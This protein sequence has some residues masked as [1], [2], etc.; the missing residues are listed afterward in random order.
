MILFAGAH[1]TNPLESL[2]TRLSL[3]SRTSDFAMNQPARANHP[4]SQSFNVMGPNPLSYP[5]DHNPDANS[6][7][8]QRE[9]QVQTD[10]GAAHSS[11]IAYEAQPSTSS[12]A[13][14][15]RVT[16]TYQPFETLLAA[17]RNETG[18]NMFY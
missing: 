18:K 13:S 17:V 7:N 8:S 15:S 11:S 4:I 1:S 12:G 14:S 5:S 16:R 6:E 10:T 9:A 2:P 3:S